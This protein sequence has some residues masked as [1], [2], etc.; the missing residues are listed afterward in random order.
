MPSTNN[1]LFIKIAYF[2]SLAGASMLFGFSVTLNKLRKSAP[3]TSETKLYGDGVALARQAL[4]RGTIYA[5]GGF[6]IFAF[7]SYKLF[8]KRLIEDFKIKAKRND[9]EDIKYL[10]ELFSSPTKK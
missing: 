8:G 3:E 2:T 7:A 9:E 4:M 5:I 6:S 1:D 10:E